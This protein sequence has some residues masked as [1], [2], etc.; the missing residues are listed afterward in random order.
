[1]VVVAQEC[2]QEPKHGDDVSVME[3]WGEATCFEFLLAVHT[4]SLDNM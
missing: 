2:C 3:S 4:F 1:M